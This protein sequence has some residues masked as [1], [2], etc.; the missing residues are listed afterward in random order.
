MTLP[1][2]MSGFLP[3][4]ISVL[5][6]LVTC[7]A[8]WSTRTL[9]EVVQPAGLD[10]A[11]ALLEGCPVPLLIV[12]FNGKIRFAN[13]ECSD[14][15]IP[16]GENP[17]PGMTSI[18]HEDDVELVGQAL[19]RMS[20]VPD[21]VEQLRLRLEAG[22]E[23]CPVEARLARLGQTD[24]VVLCMVE[25]VEMP[26][27]LV[28]ES[29]RF[30]TKMDAI[31]HGIRGPLV[32]I[33]SVTATLSAVA[34]EDAS[35]TWMDQLQL[36]SGQLVQTVEDLRLLVDLEAKRARLKEEAIDLTHFLDGLLAETIRE[37]RW[38]APLVPIVEKGVPEW[39][40]VDQLC[41]RRVLT[42]MVQH[43]MQSSPFSEIALSV[44]LKQYEQGAARLMFVSFPT[45]ENPA[46]EIHTGPDRV[47][48][49]SLDV[50]AQFARWMGG[51]LEFADADS[52]GRYTFHVSVRQTRPLSMSPE[53]AKLRGV[54]A[55][56]V[57]HSGVRRS[58]MLQRL[59]RMGMQM[60]VVADGEIALST[61]RR[62]AKGKMPIELVVMY[63]DVDNHNGA[64]L[65]DQFRQAVAKA[66]VVLRVIP[67]GWQHAAQQ[68]M[69][70]TSWQ[71]G[72]GVLR[73]PLHQRELIEGID[74]VMR[75]LN[76]PNA[77]DA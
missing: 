52:P 29:R 50:A 7:I 77:G 62:E 40:M 8:V 16:T 3:I 61:L 25:P 46:A 64:E 75:D 38:S 28:D 11:R 63:D 68:K 32:G 65:A 5:A 39:V 59:E 36:S 18:V 17:G 67:F 2:V 15:G 55:M 34:G 48:T 27:Q 22:G 66:P 23:T 21:A 14:F 31:C 41:L 1:Q 70:T 12:D 10:E 45:G 26:D 47:P 30:Q 13:G 60:E 43:S 74:R 44:S 19:K 56:L 71:F 37:H 76:F 69:S 57:D 51:E 73:E 6:P 24:R 4:L 72:S 9:G 54:R 49:Q 35:D 33:S 58:G 20:E 53:K 42:S